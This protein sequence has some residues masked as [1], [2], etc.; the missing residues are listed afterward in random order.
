MEQLTYHQ[1]LAEA[2]EENARNI[3]VHHNEYEDDE[4]VEEHQEHDYD[5]HDLADKELFNRNQERHD[6]KNI[7]PTK[8]YDDKTRNSIRYDKDVKTHIVDIDSR[9]RA[10]P[11]ASYQLSTVS[12]DA[13]GIVNSFPAS[14][15]ANF[16]F[17]LPKVIKNVITIKITSICFPNIFYTFSKAKENYGF[18]VYDQSGTRYAT[19]AGNIKY[20]V[21]IDDGN[22]KD[23]TDLITVLNTKIQLIQSSFSV[24]YDKF[25]NK[26]SIKNNSHD[27]GIAFFSP[28][29]PA[30]LTTVPFNY[31]MG[32]N[33]GFEALKY[34]TAPYVSG[35]ENVPNP[36]DITS[37]IY[38]LTAESFPDIYGD[39]YV[40]LSINDYDVIEHQNFKQTFF[41]VFAKIMLPFNSKNQLITDIDLLNVVQRQYNFLQP[42]N[43][44]KLLIT[45]YDAYGNVVDMKG[46]NFSFTLQLEEILNPS[47]YEKMREL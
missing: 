28:A 45:I 11:K 29:I 14:N 2:Y 19:P 35:N 7:I 13:P 47:M 41:P 8:D 36:S 32:Y 5:V 25:T 39:S 38:S 18:D 27:F 46:S 37:G 3:L 20:N 31:G 12:F 1:I 4:Q 22:Y 34:G 44:Q 42:I 16:T 23:I 33:L 26:I 9:F 24:T 15:V 40:Y 17:A 10:Y 43:I 30:P 21:E 6:L